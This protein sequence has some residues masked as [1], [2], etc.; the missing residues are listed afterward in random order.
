METG[1]SKKLFRKTV[2][3]YRQLLFD[4]EFEKRNSNLMNSL[5]SFLNEKQFDSLHT[6]LPIAKNK[7]PN[8]QANLPQLW[9]RNIQVITSK[10][11]F[12]Q[13]RMTNYLLNSETGIL[14][15]ERGIP[16]PVDGEEVSIANLDAILIP[17]LIADKQGNRIGYGGGYYDQLLK[18][19]KAVK[20]G[21]CLSDPVDKIVQTDE[22][23]IPLDHLITPDKIYN[24]G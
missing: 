22:W 23:D 14:T 13:K 18:E 9:K 20:I 7:E 10:T 6:F 8:I 17:L 2:L 3:H 16:E 4:D 12:A 24:Y 21:L 19:T 15:N 11:D 1:I 5:L